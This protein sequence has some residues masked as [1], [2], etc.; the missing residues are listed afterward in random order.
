MPEIL[1]PGP[2]GRLEGR[3]THNAGA[4]KPPMALLLHPLPQLGGDMHHAVMQLL[5][6][7][8]I[9]Q[10]FSVLRF[11]FRGVGRSHGNYSNG[12]GEL[13]DAT[14]ALD[15]VQ[16]LSPD[17]KYCMVAG[18]SFGAWIGM[19]LLMRRPEI[20]GFIAVSPPASLYDF[21]FLA[22]C[23][24]SGLVLYGDRDKIAPKA[25]TEKLVTHLQNQK[26]M[27]I[28]SQKIG[29][30]NH[31]YENR[32]PALRKHVTNYLAQWRSDHL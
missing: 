31:F 13:A 28:E 2:E 24:T 10:H 16:T 6:R 18:Y 20:S 30:A 27:D 17:S 4:D 7:A 21:S 5:Y 19:H 22:P 26:G 8:F 32:L 25:D 3:Y 12:V 23:P 29:G 14:A 11:N 9:E 15:W 1:F